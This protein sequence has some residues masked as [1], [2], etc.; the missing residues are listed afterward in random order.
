MIN[1]NEMSPSSPRDSKDKQKIKISTSNNSN[2]TKSSHIFEI[3]EAP[4]EEDVDSLSLQRSVPSFKYE[5]T[6]NEHEIDPYQLEPQTERIIGHHSGNVSENS[7]S[8]NRAKNGSRSVG[9]FNSVVDSKLND[10]SNRSKK[11][12]AI[13]SYHKKINMDI[14]SVTSGKKVSG[15]RGGFKKKTAGS[16]YNGLGMK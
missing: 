4:E 6:K 5:L 14:F 9:N 11:E 8:M 7:G 15:L 12:A 3:K 13:Q 16:N 1:D 2:T 10:E